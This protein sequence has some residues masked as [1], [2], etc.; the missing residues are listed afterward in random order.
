MSGLNKMIPATDLKSQYI[1]CKAEIDAAIARVCNTAS[2]IT[3]PLVEEFEVAF[4]SF[5]GSEECAAV[6]S[7]T[8][9]L[10]CALMACDIS[11][12]DE[13]ITTPHTF[14]STSEAI[15]WQGA[16]PVFVDIDS[17]Y[18]IDVTKI[19][20]AIT[21]RTKA[22]LFVDMYGQT[23][24]IDELKRIAVKH[25]LWLI[26][27]AAHSIGS[28][29]NGVSVGSLVDL[30]CFSFNPVKNLGA[31][32]D[33][34]ALTGNHE[35]ITKAKM[36][37]DH[38]RKIKWIFDLKGINARIDN[39]QAAIVQAKIPFLT[40]WLNKKREICH[41]YT[42]QLQDYVVT[43]VESEFSHHSYY[44]Y[45]IQV[46]NR[47]QFIE[48]MKENGVAVNMHYPSS[49][50]E[51]PVFAQYGGH[52]PIA[53]EVCKNIVSLPCYHTLPIESQEKI[54]KLVQDWSKND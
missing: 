14:I 43:P 21:P 36:R 8:N 50:T 49:L 40:G 18:Q 11:E 37:R 3:G 20:A 32:G 4:S 23:P 22:I 35:L 30:T 15:I 25:D 42:E 6:G 17:K 38:G 53:E 44:V 12:G 48:Y 46:K 52:C 10:M 33:A 39:M 1:E 16:S 54:I 9:A 5:V 19:E 29:F 47:D 7:G 24:D 28:A 41:R 2:Y 31:M 45:V 27:D 13:V 26:E 51:Q 34:G